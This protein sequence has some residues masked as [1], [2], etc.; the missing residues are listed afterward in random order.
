MAD[1]PLDALAAHKRLG[2]VVFL[3]APIRF[4][5]GLSLVDAGVVDYPRPVFR[6]HLEGAA[7]RG[8][9]PVPDGLGLRPDMEARLVVDPLDL[10][11]APVNS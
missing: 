4:G 3:D 6:C 8:H 9:A 11:G 1:R 2:L 10:K 7:L 5:A